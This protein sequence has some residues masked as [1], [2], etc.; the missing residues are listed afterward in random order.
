MVGRNLAGLREAPRLIFP[1]RLISK[2][3]PFHRFPFNTLD[4]ETWDTCEGTSRK[5]NGEKEIYRDSAVSVSGGILSLTAWEE[6]YND[7]EW[8]FDYVSGSI[9]SVISVTPSYG[10]IEGRIRIPRGQGLW[11]AFWLFPVDTWPPEIDIIEILGHQPERVYMTFHWLDDAGEHQSDGDSYDGPDYSEDFHV[12]SVKWEPGR[13][14]W[15]IDGAL[16]RTLE[17]P[18]IDDT[19]MRIVAN[20]AVGGYWPG[21]SDETTVF[22][23][24]MEVDYIRLCRLP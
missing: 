1:P 24:V 21:Y 4:R 22:P 10:W 15:Y 8:Q 18:Y 20:L 16:V 5:G 14:E 12:F 11:P 19:P 7:G 2:S 6:S 23:T 17:N 3:R 9:D 13:L